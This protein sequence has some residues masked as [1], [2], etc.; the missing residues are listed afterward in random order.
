MDGKRDNERAEGETES[1]LSES[2]RRG[3]PPSP[4]LPPFYT[5]TQP[6]SWVTT[7]IPERLSYHFLNSFRTIFGTITLLQIP[8]EC[9]QR[10]PFPK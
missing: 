7:T 4:G 10:I 2:E 9:S 3:A 6:T 1:E 8:L 5:A